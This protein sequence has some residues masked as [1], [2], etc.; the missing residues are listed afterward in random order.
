MFNCKLRLD[1]NGHLRGIDYRLCNLSVFES[2]TIQIIAN[3]KVIE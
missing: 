2:Q 1:E 3:L